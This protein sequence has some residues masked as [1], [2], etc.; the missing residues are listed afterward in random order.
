MASTASAAAD[1]E[2]FEALASRLA[3]EPDVVVAYLFGS[4]ARGTAGALSDVDVAV[5]L[6][7]GWA[8]Q[9][10]LE[11]IDAVADV[12]GSAHAD[13]VVLNDAPVA[14]AYRVLRDGRP[15]VVN[16]DRARVRHWVRTV[17]RYL[18]M[19]PLR[20]TLEDGLRHR[21]EE[22]RFGRP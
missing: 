7:E 21:L 12:V 4:H 16:D 9:R 13:V 11:L 22:G 6:V 2:L 19:A 14:L 10:Q 18:D 20:R 1:G 8:P 3:S 15:L 5:L 17:D